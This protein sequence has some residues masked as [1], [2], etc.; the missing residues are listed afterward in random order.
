[1][2]EP[3]SDCMNAGELG[4]RKTW[5]CLEYSGYLANGQL[6]IQQIDGNTDWEACPKYVS[7][8]DMVDAQGEDDEE[9]DED[10][11]D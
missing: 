3:C 8:T 6:Y 1:M 5:I 2:A 9:G 7:P 4:D 10:E 11:D